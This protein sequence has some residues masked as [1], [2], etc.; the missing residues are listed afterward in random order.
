MT[1]RSMNKSPKDPFNLN[2]RM[3]Q[4]VS[5]KNPESIFNKTDMNMSLHGTSIQGSQSYTSQMKKRHKSVPRRSSMLEKPK[6]SMTVNEQVMVSSKQIKYDNS[7]V[8]GYHLK[9]WHHDVNKP[10]VYGI[11]PIGKK[12]SHYLDPIL[13]QKSFIPPPTAYNINREFFM[14]NDPMCRQ[15]SPRIT[16]AEANIK[17]AKKMNFPDNGTYKINHKQVE[18]RVQGCFN[19]KSDRINEFDDAAYKGSHSPGLRI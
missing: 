12:K 1:K 13:R 7:T 15:K 16:D 11:N 18:N 4:S 10:I 8:K 19:F 5:P 2:H 17:W 3:R 9:M 6:Y 14:K